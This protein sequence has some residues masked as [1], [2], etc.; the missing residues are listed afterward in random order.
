MKRMIEL[1]RHKS[2]SYIYLCIL[3]LLA[4]STT[5]LYAAE[6]KKSFTVEAYDGTYYI[7]ASGGINVRLGPSTQYDIIGSLLYGEKITVTGKTD[8]G[9]YEIPY[10]GKT[11]YIAAKYVSSEPVS[12]LTFETEELPEVPETFSEEYGMEEEYSPFFSDTTV[13]LLLIAIIA[14]IVAMILTV[15]S[16][17]R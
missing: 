8:N 11:G 17:F 14:T 2:N 3:L 4:F 13:V 6:T 5:T 12:T 15:I 1:F 16:F 10:Q 9:W 7:S